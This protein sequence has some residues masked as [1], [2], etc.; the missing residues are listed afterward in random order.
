MTNEDKDDSPMK[1]RERRRRRIEMRRLAAICSA[2]PTFPA[3]PNI[4]TTGMKR[5][6]TAENADLGLSPTSSSEDLEASSGSPSATEE[7]D[8]VPVFGTMSF[9]GRSRVME[10]AICVRTSLCRPE[11]NRRR[12][13]H[14]F[15]VYDGHGGTR[16]ASLCRERMHVLMEEELMRVGSK[17]ESECAVGNSNNS[18]EDQQ[19]EEERWRTAMR[20]CYERMD[21]VALNT[22]ACGSVGYQ[23]TC[24]SME[25]ALAGSTAVVAVLTADHIVV[26]NCGDSR[27]V[28]CRR[29]RAVPLSSDHKPSRPDELAR[30]E[31]S[32]GRVIFVNGARVEGILATSRALGDMYLKPIV[33]A[34]P[35]I[36][37][38]K[39][40]PED[41]CLILA[42]DGLWDVL[43]NDLA[44]EVASECLRE[45]SPR[46]ASRGLS[47]MPQKDDEEALYASAAALLTRLALGRKSA[48]NISV[49]VV[50]L[51]RTY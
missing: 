50:D 13:V 22:C 35:E 26:A 12:P 6:R 41:E 11:M 44:C 23:C 8:A 46:D 40:D 28:L 33:T 20:R 32:G 7:T 45:G 31:A 10:D 5:I 15:G 4:Y 24:H 38:T 30:I 34:E 37:F 2:G 3:T 25:A 42:S 49:I 36:S 9:P 51:K 43:S 16:V 27:A 47:A 48:D 1:C 21:E 17:R 14:F 18:K 19:E 39:R 29:G